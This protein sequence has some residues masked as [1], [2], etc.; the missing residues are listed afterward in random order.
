MEHILRLRP[1]RRPLCQPADLQFEIWMDL[2]DLKDPQDLI[3]SRFCKIEHVFKQICIHKS[4]ELR[5]GFRQIFIQNSRFLLIWGSFW[6]QFGTL[7]HHFGVI[8]VF[9]GCM[10]AL[11]RVP[12][13]P[14]IDFVSFLTILGWPLGTTLGSLFHKLT[15]LRHQ[16]ACFNCRHASSWFL[17]KHL[18]D[19]WCP[20]LKNTL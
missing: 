13:W 12:E 6:R 14:N 15:D 17:I 19:F 20:N 9:I 2:Q 18:I 16:K 11:D 3:H 8:L 1:C 10:G 4:R 5:S 7:R